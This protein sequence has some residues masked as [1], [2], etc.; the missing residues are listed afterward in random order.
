MDR[1]TLKQRHGIVGDHPRLNQ[2]LDIAL[3]VAPTE[4][5]VLVVGE[6]GSGKDVFASILHQNSG[7]KHQPFIAINCGAIPE[8]TIDSELFG[9]EKGSFTSAYDQRKGYFEEVDGGMIFL[10]EIAEM[11]LATQSRLL[12]VLEN[13]EYLRVGSSK[14][15]KTDVRVVAATNKNLIEAIRKGKF[16]EDLYFRLNTVTIYVP[17]LRERGTDLE[18]LLRYFASEFGQKYGRAPVSLT[19]EAKALLY[20][21][22]WPGN[23]RELRNFTEKL[24]VLARQ[25]LVG[26]E[27]LSQHIPAREYQLPVLVDS[28]ERTDAPTSGGAGGGT[29]SD[30]LVYQALFDI[31]R[32][33]GEL[34]RMVFTLVAGPS[35]EPPRY[36]ALP[37]PSYSPSAPEGG[38][39]VTPYTE[40][41]TA[42]VRPARFAE[43]PAATVPVEESLSLDQRERDLIARALR[44]HQHNRKKAAQELGISER[45]LYRKIKSYD[46]EGA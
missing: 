38:V 41:K 2:A 16:R 37:S 10:D 32:E 9:H 34:K 33:L 8:G 4:V 13:G 27:E 1:Q 21:Y 6:N 5:T 30:E 7:R 17:P 36:P 14:V 29:V 35:F 15:R 44:K 40:P 45:T 20:D 19:E 24:T 31:R 23:V 46:L 39:Y 43:N 25:P 18:L 3:Q 26:P 28:A 22:H 42:L 11:P 12:R